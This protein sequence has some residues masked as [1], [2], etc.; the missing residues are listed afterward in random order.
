MISRVLMLLMLACLVVG[1]VEAVET[2]DGTTTASV[3]INED[4]SF[5]WTKN[6]PNDNVKLYKV[7][8]D[9]QIYDTVLDGDCG[10]G[11]YCE[12]PRYTSNAEGIHV[13]TVVAVDTMDFPSG[14]SDSVTLTV[15][16]QPP[17]KPGGCSIRVF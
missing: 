9:G 15:A 12:T 2:C 7:Y 8:K 16:N 3:D 4:Y 6:H 5:C 10:P 13:F 14:H 17:S 11:D 1:P